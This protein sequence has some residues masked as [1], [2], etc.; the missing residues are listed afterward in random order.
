MSSTTAISL[1]HFRVLVLGLFQER[2]IRIGILPQSQEIL[3]REPA[4]GLIAQQRIGP[5]QTKFRQGGHR[6]RVNT[7]VVQYPLKFL[8]GLGPLPSLKV[9][10]AARIE[11]PLI[12]TGVHHGTVEQVDGLRRLL[13]I[14]FDDRFHQ[15]DPDELYGSV[16]WTL[17]GHI[18]RNFQGPLMI[19][20]Q[21]KSDR[22]VQRDIE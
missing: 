3:V 15:R 20:D 16:V 6:V 7:R 14:G 1:L 12:G 18:I 9:G 8:R 4:A 22:R 21:G 10:N 11:N 2:D 5:G 19:M 13:V 17:R